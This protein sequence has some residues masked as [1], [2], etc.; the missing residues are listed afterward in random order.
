MKDKKLGELFSLVGI[1]N[2]CVTIRAAALSNLP[3][4]IDDMNGNEVITSK[5]RRLDPNWAWLGDFTRNLYL[6][7]SSMVILSRGYL[8][9]EPVTFR[10]YDDD[11]P[12]LK[13]R[14]KARF[15]T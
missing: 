4:S 15:L 1:V 7:Q 8:Y 12:S 2:R 6:L 5:D 14:P 11:P 9:E 10:R 13:P 3:W